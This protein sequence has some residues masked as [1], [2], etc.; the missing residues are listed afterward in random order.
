[1]ERTGEKIGDR[2]ERRIVGRRASLACWRDSRRLGVSGS[3]S[4]TPMV[5]C[6][7]NVSELNFRLMKS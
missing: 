2:R 1:M 7:T 5:C 3:L 6:L 4:G